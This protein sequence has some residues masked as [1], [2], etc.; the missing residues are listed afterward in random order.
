MTFFNKLMDKKPKAHSPKETTFPS[1]SSLLHK[2]NNNEQS[3]ST[4]VQPHN[5][6]LGSAENMSVDSPGNKRG[7]PWQELKNRENK[8]PRRSADTITNGQYF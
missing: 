1:L 3:N 2:S 8:L 6:T 5:N 7:V 4:T